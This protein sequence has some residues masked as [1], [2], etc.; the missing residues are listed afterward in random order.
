MVGARK[1]SHAAWLGLGE[2]FQSAGISLRDP[3]SRLDRIHTR[4]TA[5]GLVGPSHS[6]HRRG[7]GISVDVRRFGVGRARRTTL[8]LWQ[9]PPSGDFSLA[10]HHPVRVCSPQRQAAGPLLAKTVVRRP[11]SR[12][13]KSV[14]PPPVED[15]VRPG[16]GWFRH[17]D[18]PCGVFV[19]TPH[20]TFG[21]A[22]TSI[23]EHI[24]RR[25]TRRQRHA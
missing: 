14:C 25:F 11:E 22:E 4:R 17:D 9:I 24:G 3:C 18:P 5:M 16:R 6:S 23:G 12:Q 20:V 1:P 8:N 2:S 15:C 7:V 21:R 13:Q 10:S 19:Q